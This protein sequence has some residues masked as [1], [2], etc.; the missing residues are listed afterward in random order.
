MFALGPAPDVG[1]KGAFDA[2]K[3]PF[4]VRLNAIFSSDIRYWD[5]PDILNV[6]EEAH[7]LVEKGL[8]TGTEF[9]FRFHQPRS[10]LGW[11]VAMK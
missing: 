5:E 9:R 1:S 4:G 10:P 11:E 3:L 2:R 6:S 7:E 8:I